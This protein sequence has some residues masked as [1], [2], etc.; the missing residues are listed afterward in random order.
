MGKFSFHVSFSDYSGEKNVV[1]D[2]LSRKPHTETM[3]K[4]PRVNA[5][6]I[7]YHNELDAMK[8]RYATDEAFARI[9]D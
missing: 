9:Y 8:D 3:S 1:A 2:A 6:S 5:M 4:K 7:A